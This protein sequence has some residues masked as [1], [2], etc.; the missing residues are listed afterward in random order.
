MQQKKVLEFNPKTGTLGSPPKP[1][2]TSK[3]S[4]I[5]TTR[6][7]RDD[8]HRKNMSERISGI[9]EGECEHEII[10]E[11]LP[12]CKQSRCKWTTECRR[13]NLSL[14]CVMAQLQGVAQNADAKFNYSSVAP[15]GSMDLSK[16]PL[17]PHNLVVFSGIDGP[18]Q[19]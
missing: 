14:W 13:F 1:K 10:Q 3:P 16:T 6:Y 5:V 7:G 19:T 15:I 9:L 11:Y 4:R 17:K 2:A 8:E 18:T 12:H